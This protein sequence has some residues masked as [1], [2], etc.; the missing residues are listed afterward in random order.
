METPTDRARRRRAGFIRSYLSS[1]VVFSPPVVLGR[2][3]S[4]CCAR[5]ACVARFPPPRAPRPRRLKCTK[6]C[7]M[8]SPEDSCDILHKSSVSPSWRRTSPADVHPIDG[9]GGL[10]VEDSSVPIPTWLWR[11]RIGG[12][13]D[14]APARCPNS[15]RTVQF[16]RPTACGGNLPCAW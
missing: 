13:V 15:Q 14:S 2:G 11:H 12:G 5:G 1:A 7:A 10:N 9:K 8:L 3:A 6:N 16:E 4:C